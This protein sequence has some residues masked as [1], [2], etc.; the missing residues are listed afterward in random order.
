MEIIVDKTIKFYIVTGKRNNRKIYV[1]ISIGDIIYFLNTVYT[2]SR[3]EASF[4][5]T[6]CSIYSTLTF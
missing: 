6:I 4:V 3:T 5:L 1:N 2:L